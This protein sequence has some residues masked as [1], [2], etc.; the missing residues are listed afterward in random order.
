MVKTPRADGSYPV[1]TPNCLMMGR[2]TNAVP[3]DASLAANLKRG[4]RYQLIQQV[5]AEFWQQWTQQVTPESV[6]RQKWHETGRNLRPGDV[7]LL[8]EKT[9]IKG[10]Y[11]LGIVDTV[12]ESD[13][14]LVR[15]CTI[16]YTIPNAKDHVSVYTGGRRVTVTRSV[17]RLTLLLPVEEQQCRL[18]VV[19]N[20][21][22]ESDVNANACKSRS[23]VKS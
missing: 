18:E 7:V 14:H 13:D 1:L 11:Q 2:S 3:D 9:P 17:Q 15:S 6:I 16:S 5:M 10:K 4:D 20:V 12:K 21:L 19:E 22:K 8:H 23:V